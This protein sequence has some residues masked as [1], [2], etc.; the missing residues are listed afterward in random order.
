MKKII[1]LLLCALLMVPLSIPVYAKETETLSQSLS[2]KSAILMEPN[3][4]EILYESNAD[5]RLSPASIT[6]EMALLLVMEAI[7]R[8]D[9]SLETVSEINNC[10]TAGDETISGKNKMVLAIPR[11]LN[12]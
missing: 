5:E 2:C 3:T 8:K 6:K 10:I 9:I 11:P 4:G 7:D 12:S 1:S